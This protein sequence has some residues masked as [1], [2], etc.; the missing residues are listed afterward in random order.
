MSILIPIV[1]GLLLGGI[2][3]FI[4]ENLPFQQVVG[5]KKLIIGGYKF[6]HSLYGVILIVSSFFSREN[7]ILIISSGLGVIIEHY[8]TGGRL[9]FITKE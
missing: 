1:E 6:H 3:A 2:C 9:D 5:V 8:L 4:Y 7:A